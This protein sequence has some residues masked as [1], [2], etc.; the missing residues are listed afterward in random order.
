MEQVLA[1]FISFIRKTI[2][3]KSFRAKTQTTSV[4][5][6]PLDECA[7][8]HPSLQKISMR[9]II[10][11][12]K[13]FSEKQ[14]VGYSAYRL[15]YEAE[16]SNGLKLA[17]RKLVS[18][19]F[20][21]FMEL[22]WEMEILAKLRHPNIAQILEYCASGADKILIYEFNEKGNLAAHL[23]RYFEMRKKRKLK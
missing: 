7:S 11:A 14:V 5:I 13:N 12:T 1:K 18:G 23:C 19:T 21:D 10:T 15:V 6:S 20:Q 8:F 3:P 16:L 9:K 22:R 4:P 2:R 17:V